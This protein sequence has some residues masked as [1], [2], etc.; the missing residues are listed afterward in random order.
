MQSQFP[1]EPFVDDT[2]SDGDAD[3]EV[4]AVE[5]PDYLQSLLHR[6]EHLR[7]VQSTLERRLGAASTDAPIEGSG[8]VAVPWKEREFGVRSNSG[9]RG[10]LNRVGATA[11]RGSFQLGERSESRTQSGAKGKVCILLGIA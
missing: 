5:M 2:D 4:E 1:P 6:L 3:Q 9:W 8:G 7:S 10:V 11:R